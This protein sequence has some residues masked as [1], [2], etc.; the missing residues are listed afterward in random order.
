MKENVDEK[1]L[2]N[3]EGIYLLKEWLYGRD[4]Y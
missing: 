4:Y 3:I 1:E 2:L